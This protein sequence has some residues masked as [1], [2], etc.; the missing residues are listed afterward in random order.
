MIDLLCVNP[1]TEILKKSTN[2][3]YTLVIKLSIY[4]AQYLHSGVP[5]C[6]IMF[7]LISNELSVNMC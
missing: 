7:S 2:S 1:I 4:R 3:C 6:W 5:M